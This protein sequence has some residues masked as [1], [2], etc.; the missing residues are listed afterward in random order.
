M[1]EHRPY[2]ANG[3]S[4]AEIEKLTGPVV[5]DFGTDWCE[6]CEAARPLI[7]AAL[8]RHSQIRH[9]KFEDGK[10]RVQGRAFK[11]KLWPTLVFLRDGVEVM[12][13]VRPQLAGD[14]DHALG[15]IA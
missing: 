12:R 4:V 11:V 2:V 14:I 1:S 6:Y 13:L 8:G 5:L 3:L 7:E 15:L 9:I 10:G